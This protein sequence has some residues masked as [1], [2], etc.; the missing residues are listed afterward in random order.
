MWKINR[1]AF[2]GIK[3]ATWTEYYT[4]RTSEQ[5]NELFR[6]DQENKSSND[7]PRAN[8]NFKRVPFRLVGELDKTRSNTLLTLLDAKLDS[9]SVAQNIEYF[10]TQYSRSLSLSLTLASLYHKCCTVRR[11]F[12][13]MKMENMPLTIHL[14]GHIAIQARSR[15]PAHSLIRPPA[16]LLSWKH[17]FIAPKRL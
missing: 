17:C 5:K 2:N 8:I 15:A 16:H 10:P 12:A 3:L 13:L 9:H 7:A 11:Y 4:H 14:N 1:A 6:G